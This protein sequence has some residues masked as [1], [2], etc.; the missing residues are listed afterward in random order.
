MTASVAG[1]SW[2]AAE[3]A[4]RSA[5]QLVGSCPRPVGWRHKKGAQ[6]E[7]G[8]LPAPASQ[9]SAPLMQPTGWSVNH[10]RELFRFSKE[11][12]VQCVGKK[13]ENK[14]NQTFHCA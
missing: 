14:T 9:I 13:Q 12:Y 4:L 5:F 2:D 7:M 1:G 11:Y 6:M 10:L 8:L 3:A